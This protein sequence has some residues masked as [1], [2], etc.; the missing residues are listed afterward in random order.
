MC[1]LFDKL[2][3]QIY[4]TEVVQ[5]YSLREFVKWKRMKTAGNL[6]PLSLA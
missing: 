2:I 4:F 6:S 5:D 3:P 1:D